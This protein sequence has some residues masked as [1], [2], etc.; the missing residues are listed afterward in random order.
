MLV[1]LQQQIGRCER[2]QLLVSGGARRQLSFSPHVCV[3]LQA[4]P[5]GAEGRERGTNG[6]AAAKPLPT[7]QRLWGHVPAWW[8]LTAPQGVGA[9]LA[10][11][12]FGGGASA[13][14]EPIS[15]QGPP[16]PWCSCPGPFTPSRLG[17]RGGI[18]ALLLQQG[19]AWFKQAPLVLRHPLLQ[20]QPCAGLCVQGP[21]QRSRC[22]HALSL[23]PRV[24]LSRVHCSPVP[25]RSSLG[26]WSHR[27]LGCLP[28]V[29]SISKAGSCCLR[30]TCNASPCSCPPWAL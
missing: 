8:D 5:Q 25:P 16:Q 27:R 14:S 4:W 15:A 3:W 26:S 18:W 2:K 12:P 22:S 20:L 28:P 30:L 21:L 10:Q 1:R 13:G 7:Y 24:S 19:W 17:V 23:P 6:T 9:P 11:H 29:N